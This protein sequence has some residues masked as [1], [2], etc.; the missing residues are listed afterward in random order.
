MQ[1]RIAV[2]K[3]AKNSDKNQIFLLQKVVVFSLNM[4]YCS[5][6]TKNRP[7]FASPSGCGVL[8]FGEMLVAVSPL[9][10]GLSLAHLA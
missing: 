7:F 8:G 5:F 2:A 9:L 3:V 6:L 1:F 10:C 4:S